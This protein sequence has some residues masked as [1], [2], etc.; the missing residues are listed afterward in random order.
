M[1]EFYFIFCFQLT[2]Y[3]HLQI[4]YKLKVFLGSKVCFLGFSEEEC[5]HMTEILVENG[6]ETT[7]LDD[8][9]CS[10]VVSGFLQN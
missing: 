6:G 9:T 10:H 1:N 3:F 4:E 7:T 5:Q 2:H 8:P